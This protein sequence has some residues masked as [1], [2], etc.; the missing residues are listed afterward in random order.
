MTDFFDL[1]HL[2]S[3]AQC[4]VYGKTEEISFMTINLLWKPTGD[5]QQFRAK[6]FNLK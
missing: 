2:F 1:P 5:M 6:E 3:K 4:Q